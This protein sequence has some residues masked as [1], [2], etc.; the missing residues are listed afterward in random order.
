MIKQKYRTGVF[1]GMTRIMVQNDM[2][3]VWK[4]FKIRSPI[5]VNSNEK[6]I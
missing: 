6:P 1:R 5:F 4:G 3:Q 2:S